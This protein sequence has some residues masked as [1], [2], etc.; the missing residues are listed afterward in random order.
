MPV[1]THMIEA[2]KEARIRGLGV[3]VYALAAGGPKPPF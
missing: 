3:L 1:I 2:K